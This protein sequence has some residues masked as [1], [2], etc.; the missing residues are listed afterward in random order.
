MFGIGL[1]ISF[2]IATAV[3]MVGTEAFAVKPI[4]NWPYPP[5]P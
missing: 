4:E 2:V 5:R 3:G 1:S